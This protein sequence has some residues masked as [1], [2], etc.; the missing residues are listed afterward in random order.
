[1]RPMKFSS[2]VENGPVAAKLKS[3]PRDRPKM[4]FRVPNLQIGSL[5]WSIWDP[6]CKSCLPPTLTGGN[7]GDSKTSARNGAPEAAN[8]ATSRLDASK[9]WPF[10]A[11]NRPKTRPQR[12]EKGYGPPKNPP[13]TALFY[14][15]G[16]RG[17][18]VKTRPKTAQTRILWASTPN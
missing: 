6:K 12:D 13:K 14:S 2:D 4:S 10:W 18:G 1:M 16:P 5:R 11:Q 8:S 9:I 15:F 3:R 7:T 17:E